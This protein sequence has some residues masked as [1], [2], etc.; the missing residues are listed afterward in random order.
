[1]DFTGLEI[2]KHKNKL[3]NLF[4]KLI[5]SVD[6]NEKIAINNEMKTETEFLSSLLNIKKSYLGQDNL[7]NNNIN[8][9]NQ[10]LNQNINNNINNNTMQQQMMQQQLM[11]EQM[12]QQQLMQEQMMQQQKIEQ[13][14]ILQ[15]KMEESQEKQKQQEYNENI[16]NKVN[17]NEITVYFKASGN[18]GQSN[19]AI[20]VK[21]FKDEKVSNIIEKYRNKANDFVSNKNFIYK[22]KNI[23]TN[24]TV[25]EAGLT[26]N[27]Y[28]F[29]VLNQ[30]PPEGKKCSIF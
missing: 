8:F 30:N 13:Q 16:Q 17:N 19:A 3:L 5:N 21:C 1:M 7:Q 18:K 11:Q 12:M 22:A 20:K 15:Q 9:M 26:N 27:S 4:N 23:N 10:N 6:I 14:N 25:E 28:I 24:L 2:N 29:V